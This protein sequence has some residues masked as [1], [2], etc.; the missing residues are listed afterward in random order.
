MGEFS[1]A[2][3]G[4][5]QVP[6]KKR[7]AHTVGAEC[8]SIDLIV[9]R[10]CALQ[11]LSV[12]FGVLCQSARRCAAFSRWSSRLHQEDEAG[13]EFTDNSNLKGNAMLFMIC[14]CLCAGNERE[15]CQG[16]EF[17]WR[18]CGTQP[19]RPVIAAACLPLRAEYLRCS[20][21]NCTSPVMLMPPDERFVLRTRESGVINHHAWLTCLCRHS[22]QVH[23]I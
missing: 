5:A 3:D 19:P 17:R 15:S 9:S 22:Q 14:G 13:D 12:S 21:S 4:F 20:V 8:L 6:L 11:T 23:H 1:Q 18:V 2:N 10:Y 16:R 7:P